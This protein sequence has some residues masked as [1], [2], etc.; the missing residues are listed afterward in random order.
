MRDNAKSEAS[1]LGE[2]RRAASTSPAKRSI[3]MP[4]FYQIKA[5]RSYV[6]DRILRLEEI[7]MQT[8]AAHH[9]FC[10]RGGG[11]LTNSSVIDCEETV[12][13]EHVRHMYVVDHF[14]PGQ[15]IHYTSEDSVTTM[16]GGRAFHSR[17]Q[18]SF[19]LFDGEGTDGPETNVGFCVTIVLPS[20]I[21]LFV[22]RVMGTEAVW[23]PHIVEESL[24]FARV[25]ERETNAQRRMQESL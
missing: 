17:V 25:M 21:H 12:E 6:W 9:F 14:V 13:G 19:D 20:R 7:Y 2:E 1:G 16:P 5:P 22:A 18:C 15:S 10:V 11:L 23:K 8:S 4:Y 24:I 3:S